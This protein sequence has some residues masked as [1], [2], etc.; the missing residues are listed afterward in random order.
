M[1]IGAEFGRNQIESHFEGHISEVRIWNRALAADEV[2]HTFSQAQ[3]K[4][5]AVL[6]RGLLAQWR[7][8]DANLDEP[9]ARLTVFNAVASRCNSITCM[10]ALLKRNTAS[11]PRPLL[12]CPALGH[13][14]APIRPHPL[15]HPL[16]ISHAL[17]R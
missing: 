9:D 15:S 13:S 4:P 17:S 12:L 5:P 10:D 3:Q 1:L 7:P 6:N 2:P 16:P 11:A 8:L 14:T